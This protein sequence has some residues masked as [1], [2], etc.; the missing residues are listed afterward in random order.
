MNRLLSLL[1]IALIAAMFTSSTANAQQRRFNSRNNQVQNRDSNR[2]VRSNR[3]TNQR[4]SPGQYRAGRGQSNQR[5]T[6]RF[7]YNKYPTGVSRNRVVTKA[8]HQDSPGGTGSISRPRPNPRP[9]PTTRP[10][11]RPRGGQ[12]APHPRG[13]GSGG[14]APPDGVTPGRIPGYHK[15]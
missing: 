15:K 1:A 5:R 8:A 4:L 9:K 10:Q 2:N 11:P 12:T 6:Q 14:T 13:H 3:Q 7:G